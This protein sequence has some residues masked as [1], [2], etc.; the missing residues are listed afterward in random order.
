[1]TRT[2]ETCLNIGTGLAICVIAAIAL[3]VGSMTF[4]TSNNTA[5]HTHS[6]I[7]TIALSTHCDNVVRS[8]L[9]NPATFN[10]PHFDTHAKD[11]HLP[12][13]SLRIVRGFTANNAFG[14]PTTFKYRCLYNATTK[15]ARVTIERV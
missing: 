12:D 2:Q 11:Y 15:T 6:S 7:S 8:D 10:R 1:M 14:V 13:G 3:V 5:E 4:N 9:A